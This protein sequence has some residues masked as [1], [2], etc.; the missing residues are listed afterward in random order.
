MLYG[1]DCATDQLLSIDPTTGAATAIGPL[2]FERV[3]GLAL[4]PASAVLYG[5]DTASDQLVAIDVATGAASAL[6]QITG[7]LTWTGGAHVFRRNGTTWS[8]E[9]VLAPSAPANMD[10]FGSAVA[11]SGDT[12]V[13]GAPGP[14]LVA[15]A[16]GSRPCLR[17]QWI[18]VDRAG[19]AE[20]QRR[21]A[22]RPLRR[23]RGH[24]RRHDPGGRAPKTGT[25]RASAAGSAYVFEEAGRRVGRERQAD[26]G[27]R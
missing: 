5:S 18:P 13:V 6:A 15:V 23:L 19:R 17:S 7:P 24:R 10:I 1:T 25:P 2:G 9:A 22:R 8:E 16:T 27:T 4:D 3:E 14:S 11:I 26:L 12:V 21:R 20:G